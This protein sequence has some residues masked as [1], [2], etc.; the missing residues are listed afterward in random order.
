MKIKERREFMSVWDSEEI[1]SLI[2]SL[3]EIKS[4]LEDKGFENIKVE[5]EEVDSYYSDTREAVF[6]TW[7]RDETEEEKNIREADERRS[8]E[9]QKERDLRQLAILQEKYGNGN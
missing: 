4:E 3:A 1:G 9:A 8:F 6:I 5:F 2:Q 7:E